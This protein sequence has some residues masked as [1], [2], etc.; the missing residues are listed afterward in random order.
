VQHVVNAVIAA[1]FLDRRDVG[2]FFYDTYQT[3]VA[4]G[5]AAINAGIHVSDVAADRAEMQIGL[6]LPNG[7]GQEFGV[8]VAGSQDVEGEALR[9]LAADSRQLLQFVDE[10]GHWLCEFR[11]RVLWIA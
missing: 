9:R 6:H 4:S 11:Q 8:F 1:R 2:W 7:F 3:L 10:P 5:A